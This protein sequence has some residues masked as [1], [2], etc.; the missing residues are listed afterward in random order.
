[1]CSHRERSVGRRKCTKRQISTRSDFE[2]VLRGN[3]WGQ[4][5]T[6]GLRTICLIALGCP[7]SLVSRALVMAVVIYTALFFRPHVAK[8][9]FPFLQFVFFI[10]RRRVV[11]ARKVSWPCC[12][13]VLLGHTINPGKVVHQF[14]LNQAG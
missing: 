3:R 4:S 6:L 12:R 8:V 2:S 14:A 10:R 1:M 7:V 11:L 9:A 13:L 5:G